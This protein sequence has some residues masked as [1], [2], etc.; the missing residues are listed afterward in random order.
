V[1]AFVFL[2]ALIIATF[3]VTGR[4]DTA[5]V[6]SG[7]VVGRWSAQS[8][9]VAADL[10]D[11]TF[12]DARNGWAV[13]EGGAVLHTSNGGET[14]ERQGS[15]T[16]LTLVRVTFV[17]PQD[18][19]AVGRFGVIIHTSDGG[20]TWERQG[21]DAALDLHLAGVSFADERTGWVATESGSAILATTDGGKTWSRKP[22]GSASARSDMVFIDAL[23][24][25]VALSEDGV[26][27]TLDGGDTWEYQHS[28]RASMNGLFFLNE[29][30]GWIAG[31]RGKDPGPRFVRFLS[32][33]MVARTTD[34]GRTWA[35]H[36]SGTGKALWDVAFVDAREGWAVGAFGAILYSDDGGLTWTPQPSGTEETLRGV[37]FPDVNNGWAVGNN[38]VILKFTR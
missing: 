15:G 12:V 22:F 8:S 7:R 30:D 16:E 36:E 2:A 26:L 9:G 1:A 37:A 5:P 23:R 18:G 17:T 32:D 29:N 10:L 21:A 25:W 31:W 27:H 6:S 11:V 20:A 3:V 19:W 13:G 4:Q 28:V 34:G 33:G 38:G 35:R 14:W 24:G